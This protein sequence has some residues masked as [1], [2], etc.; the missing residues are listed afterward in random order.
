M[1]KKSNH[2]Q[3]F[4][5]TMIRGLAGRCPQCGRG[6]LFTSYLKP[7]RECAVCG[8]DL[9]HI[10]ADD[11]P[12]WATILLVGHILAPFLLG[13]LPNSS[14]PDWMLMATIIPATL[15]LTLVLLPRMKGVFIGIIWRSG[16]VGS[17]K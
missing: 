8:E 3:P 15:V 9:G 17:E 12:A 11:G 10:R 6:R 7:V 1:L 2:P 5:Q 4:S 16:C 14:W 13:I